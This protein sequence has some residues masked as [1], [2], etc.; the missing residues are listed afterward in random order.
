MKKAGKKARYKT[1]RIKAWINLETNPNKEE[2]LEEVVL[3]LSCPVKGDD[4]DGNWVIFLCTDLE[5]PAEKVLRIYALRWSIEV[6]FK[7]VKQSF[8]FLK[9]QSGRYQFSYASVHL[10]AMRYTLIFEAML[11]SGGLSYGEVRDRQ[12]GKITI[13]CYAG[14]MWQLFRGLIEGALDQLTEILG[15]DVIDTVMQAI[16]GSVDAFLNR[17]LQMEP[18]IIQSTLQAEAVG[19]L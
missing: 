13:L 6:Y 10:A 15:E 8:G 7:E 1:H 9:E 14:L 5:A 4:S 2:R 12:S 17:A 18:E 16:D 11:N 19:E 3:V